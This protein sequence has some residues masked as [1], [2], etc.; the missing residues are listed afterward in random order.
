MALRRVAFR[1][2]A[3][4]SNLFMGGDREIVQSLILL[5]GIFL[6][7]GQTLLS[8]T[9]GVGLLVGGIWV[10]RLAAK[11]D[12]ML[13]HVFIRQRKYRS[14]YLARS[15]PFAVIRRSYK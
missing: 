4:R 15:T 12:P 13:R 8:L 10:T 14:F 6:F 11:K 3:N 5:S 1:R 2:S 9:F 7:M